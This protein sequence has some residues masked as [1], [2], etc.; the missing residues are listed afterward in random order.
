MC[1]DQAFLDVGF[2]QDESDNY[3]DDEDNDEDDPF[4]EANEYPLS[5]AQKAK[6]GR[7]RET[8]NGV[9]QLL[10]GFGRVVV[11]NSRLFG[12]LL[13]I[14]F[15]FGLLNEFGDNPLIATIQTRN[16]SRTGVKETI[17]TRPAL[18]A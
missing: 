8:R 10:I 3:D 6:A 5:R 16:F 4:E 18:R 9:H 11:G 17:F 14:L 1:G 13:K 2:D 15:G 12:L 7:T